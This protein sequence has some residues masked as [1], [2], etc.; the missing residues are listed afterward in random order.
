[1]ADAHSDADA[2][3][4]PVAICCAASDEAAVRE[5]AEALETRGHEVRLVVGVDADAEILTRAI[6]AQQGRGLFVLCRSHSLDRNAVDALREVLRSHDVP[7]G[8]TLTL[9]VDT[10]RPREVEERIVSVLRRMVTGRADGRPRTWGMSVPVP[11]VEDTTIRRPRKGPGGSSPEQL[12][13]GLGT[14]PENAD[15]YAST[16]QIEMTQAARE[17]P[18]VEYTGADHTAVAHEVPPVEYTGADH[19]AVARSPLADP[20]PPSAMAP[21]PLPPTPAPANPLPRPN[22]A[23]PAVSPPM[24]GANPAMPAASPAMPAASPPMPGA[25]A[26][27]DA[28]GSS[29]LPLTPVELGSDP[30]GSLG[31]GESPSMSDAMAG[32]TPAPVSADESATDFES[33]LTVGG[34]M[35]R[36]LGSPAGL[37]VV[38]GGVVVIIAAVLVISLVGGDEG[39]DEKVASAPAASSAK[40]EAD[41]PEQGVADVDAKAGPADA[42]AEADVE[43]GD[44]PAGDEPGHTGD[45]PGDGP[46][47]GPSPLAV[48]AP[49]DPPIPARTF[50]PGD[51]PPEVA[52]ALQ[53]REVR[54]LDVF[55][56]APERAGNLGFDRAVAYCS[57]L[58]VAGLKS[59]RVPTIGELNAMANAKMLGKS[60]YWSSTP[61]DSFGDERLVINGKK[62]SISAVSKTWDGARIV[63]IRLRQP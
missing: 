20:R 12:L 54:A 42:E 8:R 28:E 13:V 51:D 21:S 16:S 27:L 55:L 19:T 18:P 50:D 39:D 2:G 4:P 29:P 30:G 1:M 53:A 11:H 58:E 44:P 3:A 37:A 6:S 61:G 26:L 56:V 48:I 9:A 15:P 47:D 40:D 33:P 38:L 62:N 23:M 14:E 63:C 60:I 10:Q 24:P 49:G 7:F 43:I 45:G 25:T 36:A 57:E 59:W 35:G 34:R 31:F 46:S 5:T 52:E 22:P 32:Y 17:V 41:A